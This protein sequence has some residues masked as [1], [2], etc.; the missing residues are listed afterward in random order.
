MA[1]HKSAKKRIRQNLKRKLHNHS[2]MSEYRTEI[3]NMRG[4]L[5]ENN[6]DEALKSLPSI[7]KIIDKTASRGLIHKKTAARQK[8]RL[9]TKVNS[10]VTKSA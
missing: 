9:A 2:K 5:S 1:H 4:L 10:L 3:K 8:S 7:Y 6:H